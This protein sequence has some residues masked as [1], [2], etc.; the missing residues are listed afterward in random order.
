MTTTNLSDRIDNAVC[1]LDGIKANL[2]LLSHN[3]GTKADRTE[4]ETLVGDALSGI[5]QHI[6]RISNEL[7]NLCAVKM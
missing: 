2:F 1:E 4:D 3:I 7:D 5:A 6:E